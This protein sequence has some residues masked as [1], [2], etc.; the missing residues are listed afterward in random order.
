LVFK[1]GLA[2][3]T[4]RSVAKKVGIS[5]PAIYKHFSSKEELL[6][7]LLNSL[8]NPWR[9]ALQTIS[10]KQTSAG[11]RLETIASTHIDFLFK[12][13]LNPVVFFSEAM[14]PEHKNLNKVLQHN[15]NFINRLISEILESGLK[16]GELKKDIRI[17]SATSC[18]LGIIQSSVIKWTVTRK[19]ANLKADTIKNIN[20]FVDL[21]SVDGG[22]R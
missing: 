7:E 13:E 10:E 12:K 8:F 22:K 11:I 1:S 15:L 21:I 20:F 17:E 9:A 16:T 2:N 5:E 14:N 3:L 18:I 4:V 19:K 6:M